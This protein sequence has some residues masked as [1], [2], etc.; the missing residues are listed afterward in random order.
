M[1]A[2]VHIA[3]VDDEE[4][5]RSVVARYL[6]KQGYDVSEAE[7][8][9]ALRALL[10]ERPVDLVVLDVNM[11]GE[12]GFSLARYLRGLGP[13]GIIMLTGNVDPVDRVVGL[14]LGADDYVSKPFD[15]RELLARVRAVLRRAER[16]E[17]APA[18]MG[19]EVRVGRNTYNVETRRLYASNGTHVPLSALETA[20]LHVFATN[21]NKVLTRDDILD[22]G[23]DPEA[24][25]FS[26]SVDTRVGRLRRKLEVDPANPQTIRTVHGQGYMFVPGPPRRG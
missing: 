19:T 12:D 26:R 7:G 3:V 25:P 11:P 5:L 20:L 24:E 8:G 18:T 4:D 13:I 17:E 10:A 22:L 2:P 9:A 15:L 14:E 16:S 1:T 21:P 23:G 6:V